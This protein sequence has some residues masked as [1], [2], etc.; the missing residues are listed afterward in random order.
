TTVS[1]TPTKSSPTSPN[2]TS[3]SGRRTSTQD[4]APSTQRPSARQTPRGPPSAAVKDD[5]ATCKFCNRRF[6]PDRL[7]IHEDICARTVKKKRKMYDATKHRVQGTELEPFARKTMRG[8][9]KTSKPGS[10]KKGS[11][12]QT[13]NEFISTIRA[14]KM[15]QAHLAKGGKLSDLPPPPTSTNPDYVQCP[16]CGRRFNETA[17]ARHIPKCATFEFNKPRGSGVKPTPKA[18]GRGP[19]R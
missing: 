15:A 18:P 3:M 4:R 5:L 13:H 10:G 6:A 2:K 16:H 17:A 19:Y 9:T 11:W 7:Q 8:Q 14:A 12:R 1:N